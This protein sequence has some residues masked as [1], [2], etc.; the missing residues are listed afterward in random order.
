MAA[1]ITVD[2]RFNGPLES[3]NGGYSAG[4]LA[5]AV[6]GPAAVSLRSPVPLDR[7]LTVVAAADGAVRALDGDVLVMEARPADPLDLEPPRTVSVAEARVAEERYPGLEDGPFSRCFVCGRARD[8][9][10]GVFAGRL[11]DGLVAT[12]W[13]P[14]QLTA[15]RDGAVA[16]EFVWSVLD[17]PTYFA[18]YDDAATLSFLASLR[19]RIDGPVRVGAEHVV[20]AWPIARDGRKHHAGGAVLS[21][22]GETLA[23]GRAL[24]IEARG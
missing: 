20:I 16:P 4:L 12:T 23:V 21:A 24:L 2:A 8:D 14:D 18:L 1:T 6:D 10:F 22:D 11:E 9:A 3:G 19:V 13:T 17:C 15:G 5:A 7:P